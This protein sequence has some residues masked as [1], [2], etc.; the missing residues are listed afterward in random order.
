VGLFGSNVQLV[1][2]GLVKADEAYLRESILNPNA[3]IVAGYQPI[4]PTFQGLV[5]EEGVT[6]LI[7]YMKSLGRPPGAALPGGTSIAGSEPG[8]R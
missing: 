4:M 3:K 8:K 1:G 5:T 7:E 6:H 2:G